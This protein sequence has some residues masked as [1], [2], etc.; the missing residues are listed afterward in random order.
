MSLPLFRIF[1]VA[2]VALLGIALTAGR[3]EAEPGWPLN[4]ENRGGGY[5][6]ARYYRS[7]V[8]SSAV[9]TPQ[10]A[11]PAPASTP[12]R[13]QVPAQARIWFDNQPTV[14]TGTVREFV[15][16]PLTPGREYSYT[17]RATWRE[18]DREVARQRVVSFKAGDPVSID[19]TS[20]V[21]A[22]R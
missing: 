18:G 20:M 22:S 21:V 19:F 13:I 2:S 6:S 8:P 4:P 1:G 15:A 11:I 7:V 16:S 3:S 17:V 14:Q 9:F 10:S 12:I 5:S